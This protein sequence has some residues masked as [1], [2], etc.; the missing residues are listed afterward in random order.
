MGTPKID[1]ILHPVRMR[2]VLTLI[3]NQLTPGEIA[4]ELPDVSQATLY[5]HINTLYKGGILEVV[6]EHKVKNVTERV[7][8]VVESSVSLTKDDL[9]NTTKEEHMHYFTLFTSKLL[10]DFA[11]Y[12]QQ[13]DFN[14]SRD[15][16][17][18]RQAPI[19]ATNDELNNLI[20]Q[21]SALILPLVKNKPAPGRKRYIFSTILI[22]D[23]R[24]G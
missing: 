23:G 1:L 6:D 15:I 17:S 10:D 13:P 16:M 21:M 22:P 18:Y 8:S 12:L 14:L 5:R 3:D 11:R 20:Q 2:I 24:G 4:N 9:E 7:F 19:F